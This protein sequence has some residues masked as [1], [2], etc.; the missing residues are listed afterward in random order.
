MNLY[1]YKI[2]RSLVDLKPA[3]LVSR[4][5][6]DWVVIDVNEGT[7]KKVAK[8]FH[9]RGTEN[10]LIVERSLW[11]HSE[12]Y[13]IYPTVSTIP[14]LNSF[15]QYFVKEWELPR[16]HLFE[17]NSHVF[18]RVHGKTYHAKSMSFYRELDSKAMAIYYGSEARLSRDYPHLGL[19]R[20]YREIDNMLSEVYE[21]ILRLSTEEKKGR[22]HLRGRPLSAILSELVS[23]YEDY[24]HFYQLYGERYGLEWGFVY[25]DWLS[26]AW[27]AVPVLFRSVKRLLVRA[28]L[29]DYALVQE[30]RAKK[31][32]AGRV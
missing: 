20:L 27:E 11:E 9:V 8:W 6:E 21:I 15:F 14:L 29:Y 24:N 23:L 10:S 3:S 2:Y 30:E 18:S 5:F 26:E 19:F 1:A 13:E 32:P 28:S 22:K 16:I 12:R 4:D 31:A 7:V 17:Y 25:T